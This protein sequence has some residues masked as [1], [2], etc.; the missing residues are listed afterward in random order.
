MVGWM[1]QAFS[2]V[3]GQNPAHTWAPG[4]ELLPVCQRCTGLYV[5]AAMALL[6]L[7]WFRPLANARYC[8][9]HG[10][11]LLL[12]APFGFHLVPQDEVLRTMSGQWFGF[13]V[14]GLLWLLPGGKF[15]RKPAR[16]PRSG[17]I[18]L[19]I[20]ATSLVLLP[21]FARWGGTLAA[22]SLP[23]LALAGLAVVA[24]LLA[25][26][27]IIFFADLFAWLRRQAGGA[28]S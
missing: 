4:G 9:F 16:R 19:I 6:L 22:K 11:L 2:L 23:W 5:G 10:L 24:G 7:L 21:V 18:H 8:W 20:G 13:G 28:V 26:N 17:K 1:W 25:A 27:M 15:F 14:V 12:M 3:C